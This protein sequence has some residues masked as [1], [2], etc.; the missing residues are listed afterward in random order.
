MQYD[1]LVVTSVQRRKVLAQ[2]DNARDNVDEFLE[3]RL[4][5]RM[6]RPS[7]RTPLHRRVS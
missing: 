5:L 4:P 7:G 3:V 2:F 1:R 6:I